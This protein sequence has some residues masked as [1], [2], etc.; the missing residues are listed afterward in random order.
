MQTLRD[1]G[2]LAR[3]VRGALDVDVAER[4]AIDAFPRHLVVGGDDEVEV[5][6]CEAAQLVRLVRFQDVRLE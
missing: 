2:L 4:D 5:A 3:V 6:Q 1:V